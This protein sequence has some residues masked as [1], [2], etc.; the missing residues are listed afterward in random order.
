M[1]RPPSAELFEN[2]KDEDTL[3]PY[4]QLDPILELYVEQDKSVDDIVKA[5][6]TREAAQKV[7]NLVNKNEY[8]RRQ[9]ALGPRITP[10][11][12]G[13]E[14]RYPITSGFLSS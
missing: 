13:R 12:F 3:P 10:R 11:A 1:T 6:F 2:Q 4:D 5:G 7:I 14:R 9:L 8:K